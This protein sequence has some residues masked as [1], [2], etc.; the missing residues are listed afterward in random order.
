MQYA[1]YLVNTLMEELN[2]RKIIAIYP[3]RFQPFHNNHY[4]AYKQLVNEFGTNNV[5][6]V[7]S[8]A[9]VSNK[10]QF[11][12]KDKV[13]IITSIYHDIPSSNIINSIHKDAGSV[14]NSPYYTRNNKQHILSDWLKT[15]LQQSN[16]NINDFGLVMCIGDKDY[17]TR[18][19]NIEPYTKKSDV[20][21]FVNGHATYYKLKNPNKMYDAELITVTLLRRILATTPREELAVTLKH[22]YGGKIIPEETIHLMLDRLNINDTVNLNEGA[23]FGF[24]KHVEDLSLFVDNDDVNSIKLLREGGN[25]K[26]YR[27]DKT[28]K[29]IIGKGDATATSIPI[30]KLGRSKVVNDIVNLFAVLNNK[31]SL[32]D[33]FSVIKSGFAFNGSSAHIFNNDIDDV[34]IVKYKPEMGDVDI[35]IPENKLKIMRDYFESIEPLPDYDKSSKNKLTNNM[36][37]VGTSRIGFKDQV[38]ALFAYYIREDDF[39]VIQIDFEGVEYENNKPTDFA[40]YSRGSALDDIKLGIKGLVKTELYKAILHTISFLG[41]IHVLLKNGKLSKKGDYANASG[42]GLSA[43][44][45][46]RKKYIKGGQHDEYGELHVELTSDEAKLLNSFE[47]GGYTRNLNDI[48]KII[49]GKTPTSAELQNMTSFVK[50]IEMLKKYISPTHHKNIYNS[51]VTYMNPYLSDTST[52]HTARIAIDYFKKNI[53]L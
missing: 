10:S 30:A 24:I 31:L 3:G 32:W 11:S 50:T 26:A 18:A 4:L 19:S 16:T 36:Y 34:D 52:E 29:Q 49:F 35:T 17:N 53:D 39:I 1:D 42:L 13:E 47:S 9:R 23:N 43:S 37:L 5:Y 40:K 28:I 41:K 46:L 2:D 45:G 22:V 14:K 44:Y 7:T 21:N 8:D 48:F 20:D 6:I 51:F 25:S 33:D 27:P 15:I 12:F 38:V